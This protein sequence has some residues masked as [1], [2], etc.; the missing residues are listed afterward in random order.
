MRLS[1]CTQKKGVTFRLGQ[2]VQ[3]LEGD[4]AV[5]TVILANGESL[6]ADLVV[7]GFGVHPVTDY[8]RDVPLNEDGSVSVD[9][10]LNVIADGKTIDS[11][12]AAGDIARFPLYGATR[13]S[14]SSTGGWRNSRAGPRP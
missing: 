8:L 5:Q 13:R 1:A 7:I 6:S 3:A 14:A 11:L 10:N 2:Q 4:N 12:Y 9:A